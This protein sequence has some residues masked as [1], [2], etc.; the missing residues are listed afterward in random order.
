[1]PSNWAISSTGEVIFQLHYTPLSWGNNLTLQPD[2]VTWAEGELR[3]VVPGQKYMQTPEGQQQQS[4]CKSAFSEDGGQIA[5]G[6]WTDW[7]IEYRPDWR[8]RAAGGIG[9]TRIWCNGNSVVNYS[10]PNCVNNT[11]G[12]YLK[13]GCYKSFWKNSRNG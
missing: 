2:I 13:F 3:P 1:M 5:K 10:G 4:D 9:V 7:V 6:D 8:S 11:L 12:P